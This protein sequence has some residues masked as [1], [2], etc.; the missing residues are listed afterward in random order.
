MKIGFNGASTMKATLQEDLE[1]A[2]KLGYDYIEIWAAKLK[3]YLATHSTEDLVNRFARS[4][5]KPY[6]INSI[7]MISFR[8][9]EQE[10]ELMK[11]LESLSQIAQQLQCPYIVV[12]PSIDIKNV[13]Q[14]EIHQE[15]VRILNKMAPL[16]AKYQVALAFEFLGFQNCTVNTLKQAR[17]IV[18]EVNRDNVGMVVDT[19]HFFAND[20]KLEDLRQTDE[21][22]IFIFHIN[23]AEDIPKD[24]LSDSKR[25]LP[26]LGVIPLV[27]IIQAI[28]STGYDR[29]I[30]IEM[31][32][33]EYWEWTA[34]KVG[35]MAKEQTE[36]VLKLA[37]E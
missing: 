18:L 29:M 31:F 3:H 35:R 12:V 25:L 20:S 1:A 10:A 21:S 34:E 33:P 28:Q 11:E 19:F 24:Q 13:T 8:S 9:A 36:K 37:M 4:E 6:A 27:D 30:S 16:A 14:E 2:E 32:R 7:E 15:T 22:H 17:E 5:V 26:G 23:D